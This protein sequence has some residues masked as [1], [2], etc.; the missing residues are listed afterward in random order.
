MEGVSVTSEL[1]L[2]SEEY[3]ISCS[4]DSSDLQIHL[5]KIHL[6]NHQMAYFLNKHFLYWYFKY[7]IL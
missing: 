5:F 6:F 2:E 7:F 1:E 4:A 3:Q